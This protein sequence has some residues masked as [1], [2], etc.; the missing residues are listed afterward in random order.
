MLT[1]SERKRL[2]RSLWKVRGR[3]IADL[4]IPEWQL[5]LSLA[6]GIEDDPKG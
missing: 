5:N 1:E 3:V 2:A 6:D 4:G